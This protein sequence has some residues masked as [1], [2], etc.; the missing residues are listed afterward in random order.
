MSKFLLSSGLQ[1]TCYEAFG[2]LAEDLST[3]GG[4]T[5]FSE[6]VIIPDKLY[7]SNPVELPEEDG[8]IV[9]FVIKKDTLIHTQASPGHSD[10]FKQYCVFTQL[11]QTIASD[12]YSLDVRIFFTNKRTGFQMLVEMIIHWSHQVSITKTVIF[13]S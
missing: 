8:E 2:R 5:T 3:L 12:V 9:K 10:R 1:P 11:E 7:E 13:K 4:Y 6:N